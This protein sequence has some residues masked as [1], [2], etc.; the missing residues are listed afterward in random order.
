MPVTALNRP[1]AQPRRR[2]LP[3]KAVGQFLP[4]LTKRA[5]EKFGFATAAIATDWEAIVGDELAAKAR[6]ERLTWPRQA[7][8][9]NDDAGQGCGRSGATL[10]LRVSPASALEIDYSRGLLQDRLNAYFGYRAIAK[11]KVIQGEMPQANLGPGSYD[12]QAR[13]RVNQ[14]AAHQAMRTATDDVSNARLRDAL[15]RLSS[16]VSGQR[17]PRR[18]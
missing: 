3:G 1:Q 7:G 12:G 17:S 11:I 10:T 16:N 18:G 8:Q 4:K 6:P 5:F 2:A 15:E 14:P 9:E 13:D